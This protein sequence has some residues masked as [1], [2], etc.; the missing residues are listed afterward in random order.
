MEVLLEKQTKQIKS[1]D[2]SVVV[3]IL[4]ENKKYT[5]LGKDMIDWVAQAVSNFSCVCADYNGEDI[6]KFTK[7]FSFKHNYIVVL[8]DKIPL[9]TKNTIN[10]LIEYCKFKN[11]KAC[12]LSG[13]YVFNGAYLNASENLY[14]DSV[15]LQNQED[16]YLVENKKN[17]SFV[18][19]VLQQR[20]LN[21]HIQN[22]VEILNTKNVEIEPDVVLGKNVVIYKG[23][24]IKGNTIVQ[25]GVILKENN[26]I[27][28]CVIAKDCC[29]C[30][31]TLK[32]CKLGH[33]TIV[34][35]YCNLENCMIGEECTITSNLNLINKKIKNRS[36]V[37]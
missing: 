22:G 18:R 15:Y 33:S 30:G 34:M 12:K 36:N 9:I 11:I 8:F 35:P 3:L 2:E 37:K 5:I 13:G 29:I 32:K 19:D 1:N 28:D 20:I 4:N 31:S 17:L 23:N 25:D 14:Y 27:E 16:F 7:S 26:I 10:H 24:T 21:K 6:L